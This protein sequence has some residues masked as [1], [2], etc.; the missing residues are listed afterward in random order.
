MDRR[1]HNDPR[2]PAPRCSTRPLGAPHLDDIKRPVRQVWLR[3]PSFRG[4]TEADM[5]LRLAEGLLHL[6]ALPFGDQSQGRVVIQ[7]TVEHNEDR[8]DQPTTPLSPRSTAPNAIQTVLLMRT[9]GQSDLH[10]P[11]A[12]L[13][14]ATV[15]Q[16]A[17][18]IAATIS[19]RINTP[20]ELQHAQG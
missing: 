20:P 17:E 11:M 5:W 10:R 3:S 8:E 6:L 13:E 16:L 2:P 4:I 7:A 19:Q 15:E 9:D 1:G 14:L 12:N 18:A